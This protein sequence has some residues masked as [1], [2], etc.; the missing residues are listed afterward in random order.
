MPIISLLILLFLL[1]LAVL[2]LVVF[3]VRGVTLTIKLGRAASALGEAQDPKLQTVRK[4]VSINKTLTH[5]W[6]EYFRTLHRPR[7]VTASNKDTRDYR[8]TVQAASIFTNEIIVDSQLWTEFFKHLPGV[9]TGLGIIGTFS[10]LIRGLQAFQVSSDSAVVRGGLEGLMHR[11][12]DAFLIS[13]I[14]IA[15]AMIAT[16]IERWMVTRLY[17]QVEG[18]TSALD[19]LFSPVSDEDY[20]ARLTRASEDSS[21]QSKILKDALVGELERILTTLTERQIEAQTTGMQKLGEGIAGSLA[22]PLDAIKDGVRKNSDGN[23][24]AVTQLL[25]DVLAGFSQRIEDLFGGQITGINSLQQ[26]T[27]DAL[28]TAVAKLNQMVSSVEQASTKSADALNERLISALRDM[29]TH[30]K[31]ANERMAAFV[32]KIQGTVDQSQNETNRKLQETLSQMGVA[33]E[34]QLAALREQGERSAESQ[35]TRDGAASTRTDEMLQ[36]IGGRVEHVLTAMSAQADKHA[37]AQGQREQQIAAS[38]ASTVEHLARVAE[39]MMTEARAVAAG[40][41]AAV[42]AMRGATTSAIDKM[43]GGSETLYLAASDFKAAGESVTNV[44]QQAE[45]LSQGLRQSAGSIL[46]VSATLQDVVTD[47]AAARESISKM[48]QEMNGIVENARREAG[49]ASEVI[50]RIEAASQGLGQAHKQAEE[51]LNEVTKILAATHDKYATSLTKAL[52]DQYTT[53]YTR[54]SEAT[55]LLHGAIQELAV[56]VQPS[57]KRAAE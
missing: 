6:S 2:F 45:A 17:Q 30:Q 10:G 49:L 11:V 55:G 18:V 35:L 5:L 9:F 16:L 7:E 29:E 37:Q 54:L 46:D 38:T 13:A 31:A 47:H 33:V 56:T 25:T 34:A 57:I 51:Y 42:D 43:N 48:I 3:V 28:G 26:Q 52:G 40:V 19:A 1:G 8:S 23:N 41:S 27:I 50:E 24:E 44:F 12:G 22:G 36:A 20:L 15:L 4:I 14:S 32:E 21:A 53:F 39:T